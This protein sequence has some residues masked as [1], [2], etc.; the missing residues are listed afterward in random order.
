MTDKIKEIIENIAKE[1]YEHGQLANTL[2]AISHARRLIHTMQR[3]E[4]SLELV[5]EG[6]KIAAKRQID[7]DE[8]QVTLRTI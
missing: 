8:F 7:D 4:C 2:E 5:I 3:H 1:Y 6:M